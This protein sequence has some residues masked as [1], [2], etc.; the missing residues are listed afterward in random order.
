MNLRCAGDAILM[1]EARKTLQRMMD[2]LNESYK[3]YKM[4]INVE[5]TR[6][7]LAGEEGDVGCLVA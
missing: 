2:K 6:V 1:A 5:R 3:V 7:M 4:T